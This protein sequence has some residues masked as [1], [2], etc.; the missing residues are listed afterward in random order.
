VNELIAQTGQEIGVLVWTCAFE[1]WFAKKMKDEII[2][3]KGWFTINGVGND[4]PVRD[5]GLPKSQPQEQP[6]LG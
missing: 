6:P 5:L 1:R 3:A 2:S 4:G